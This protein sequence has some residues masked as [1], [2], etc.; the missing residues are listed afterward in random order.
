MNHQ[1]N[2]VSMVFGSHLYGLDT[3]NSDF[4][5]KSIYVA[6]LEDIVS[7]NA[8]DIIKSSTGP[9][10]GKNSAGDVDNEIMSLG[11]FVKMAMQGQTM[12][13]DML[14]ANPEHLSFNSEIW[15]DLQS[16]R[17]MFYTK[18]M[19]ALVGYVKRQANKYG[20]KGSRISA[21]KIVIDH[22]THISRLH[23]ELH[24]IDDFGTLK[25]YWDGLPLNE[26]CKKITIINK[27]DKEELYYEVCGKKYGITNGV[28]YVLER[29]RA[30]Y[31]SYGHRA[32][33]AAAN[34][35]IDWKA[36]SHALRAGYQAK[37]IYTQNTMTYPIAERD[38]LLDVKLGK[39]DYKTE[40]APV[41]EDLVAEVVKLSEESTLPEKCNEDYWLSWLESWYAKIYALEPG[42]KPDFKQWQVINAY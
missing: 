5:Y 1:P 28:D 26:F 8:P 30:M 33:L 42:A 20:I 14:H 40:V 23:K 19:S 29:I 31:N 7:G 4:D 41:L 39:L 36:V 32:Q 24:G 2:V 12:A 25:S 11:R 35:G 17:S 10:N 22:L 15:Q 3:P 16:K 13:L 27:E 38:F 21:M 18:D 6:S 34:S 9:K 37:Q